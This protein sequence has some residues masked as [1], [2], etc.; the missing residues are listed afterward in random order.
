ME[1]LVRVRA[2]KDIYGVRGVDVI[3]GPWVGCYQHSSLVIEILWTISFYE[4]VSNLT[5]TI[6]DLWGTEA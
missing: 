4:Y 2:K 1:C 3:A 5:D 6:I